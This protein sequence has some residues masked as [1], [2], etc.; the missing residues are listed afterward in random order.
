MASDA[1]TVVI[2]APNWLG[3]AVMALPAM[4]ALRRAIHDRSLVVAARPSIAPLFDEITSAAPDRVLTVERDSEAAMLRGVNADIAILLPNSFRSAWVAR[5]GGIENRWGYRAHGRSLLLTR[6]VKPPRGR[7]HQSDYYLHLVEA[8][9]V[10]SD[11]RRINFDALTSQP[12]RPDPAPGE[13][14][15]QERA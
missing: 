5:Q 9:H 7:R 13:E 4:A 12:D 6:S 3:D 1:Q 14:P 2:R 11:A 15:G 8:E 10:R